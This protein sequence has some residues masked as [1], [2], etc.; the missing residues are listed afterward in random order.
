MSVTRDVLVRL[1]RRVLA[2]AEKSMTGRAA[3]FRDRAGHY[4]AVPADTPRADALQREAEFIDDFGPD[5]SLNDI[6]EVLE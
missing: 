1:H 5:A 2:V 3:V 6:H 4:H